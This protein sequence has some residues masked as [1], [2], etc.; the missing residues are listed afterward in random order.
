MN[1]VSERSLNTHDLATKLTNRVTPKRLKD[2][3][4][5][6][7]RIPSPSGEE[8]GVAEFYADYLR[9]VGLEV[10]LDEEYLN[11]PSVIARLR[12]AGGGS[13]LQLDGHTDTI[14]AEGP[15]PR[16]REGYIHG[17]GAEDMKGPL[18]AIAE[19][20]HIIAESEA[21][22]GG[23][24][25]I[26]AHGRHETATNETLESLIRKGV[27]GDAVIVAELGG[28][29]LPVAGMGL[30]F[31]EMKI[32]REGEVVHETVAPPEAP[33][34]LL[35]GMR[36]VRLLEERARELGNHIVPDLGPESLFI[37]RFQSG[38]HF[39][40]L[41]TTCE[42]AGTRRFGPRRRIADVRSD[43]DELT[44]RVCEEENVQVEV[45]LDGVE[46]FRIAKDERIVTVIRRA[47]KQVTGRELPLAGTRTAAN[48][49]HFVHLAGVPA[50]YYGVRHLTAHSDDERVELAELV[51]A[52]KVYIHAILD[53]LGV[54]RGRS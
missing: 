38:D 23:D 29:H 32:S 4:L 7:V 14:A 33:H 5:D 39:N 35:A 10:E 19:A 46:G 26:T 30:A 13:T 22:L 36:A 17:R 47:Y 52:T 34:P 41:P 18:A 3:T 45:W 24:L 42:I 28:D 6:L 43:L 48:V 44:R 11:S 50:V 16:Y 27:H 54:A 37:G 2:L 21:R 8:R 9:Q 53:Y 49:P 51:R 31:F 15:T 20:A 40:R 25:L 1:E 12:S